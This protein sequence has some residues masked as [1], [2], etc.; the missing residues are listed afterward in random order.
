MLFGVYRILIF[1][2][3]FFRKFL[4]KFFSGKEHS[5]KISAVKHCNH[6][7]FQS[8]LSKNDD[9]C[10]LSRIDENAFATDTEKELDI[11]MAFSRVY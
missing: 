2:G 1:S 9:K 5:V 4:S 6:I 8:E 3:T 10:V 7:I 11:S